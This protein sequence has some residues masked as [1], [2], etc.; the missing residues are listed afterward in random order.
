MASPAGVEPATTCLEGRCSI[1]LSYGLSGEEQTMKQSNMEGPTRV[2]YAG[3]SI[4]FQWLRGAH[5]SLE[6]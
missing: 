6:G 1:Q 4:P 5:G 2:Q 3:R